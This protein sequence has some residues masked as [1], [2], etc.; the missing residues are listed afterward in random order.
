MMSEPYQLYVTKQCNLYYSDQVFK[1]LKNEGLD[2]EP[3]HEYFDIMHG[4]TKEERMKALNEFEEWEKVWE[5]VWK[6]KN[7]PRV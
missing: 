5:K 1:L 2:S 3:L 6:E 4:I 7:E